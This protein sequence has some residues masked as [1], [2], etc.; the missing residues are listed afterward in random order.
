MCTCVGG[1]A[2]FPS[3]VI[4]LLPVFPFTHHTCHA[5][6]ACVQTG[7]QGVIRSIV[8]GAAHETHVKRGAKSE[9]K[10]YHLEQLVLI[11]RLHHYIFFGSANQVRWGRAGDTLHA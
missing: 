3:V 5:H 1:H 8:S 10:L 6:H 2:F 4:L 11:I 9:W 7:R